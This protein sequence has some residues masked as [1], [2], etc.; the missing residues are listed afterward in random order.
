MFLGTPVLA[1]EADLSPEMAIDNSI[2]GDGEMDMLLSSLPSAEEVLAATPGGPV[3]E[4]SE[5]AVG[6]GGPPPDGPHPGG[7]PHPEWHKGGG[8]HH[9]PFGALRGNLALTTDQY[10]K[11]YSI[12]NQFSDANGPKMLKLH[13][14]HRQLKESLASADF[15][16]KRSSDIASSIASVKADLDK[17]HMERMIACAGV[18]TSDQRKALHD[19]MIKH[20]AMGGMHH[21]H[22]GHGFHGA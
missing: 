16:A 2:T 21:G 22:G 10:E 20:E 6:A 15:D 1:Q 4:V 13:Q 11:L 9:G 14:L 18:L 3:L 19:E 8:H 7:P 12:K 17:S 5:D